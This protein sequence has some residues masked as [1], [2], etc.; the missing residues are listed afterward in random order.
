MYSGSIEKWSSF[1]EVVLIAIQNNCLSSRAQYLHENFY[2][3]AIGGLL[4]VMEYLSALDAY[5]ESSNAASSSLA[6]QNIGIWPYSDW[7][8][9]YGL[10]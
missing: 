7:S 9:V 6:M 3:L 8:G 2:Y 5:T 4:S 10:A 1:S